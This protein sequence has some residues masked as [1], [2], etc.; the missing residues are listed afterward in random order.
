[1][2]SYATLGRSGLRVSPFTLGTMTF[3]EDLGWGGSP[4]ESTRILAAYLD[5]GGNS[6]HP[7]VYTNGHSEVIIGDYLA[8]RPGPRDRIV[9]GTKFFWNLRLGDP[10][11]G[12]PAARPSSSSW[13]TRCAACGPL[14]RHLLAAQLRPG[15]APPRP[16]A[17]LTTSSP[18]ARSATSG[19]LTCRRGRRP[20]RR[21]S[22][23]SAAGRRSSPCSWSTPCSS[24]PRR[25]SLSRWP[26]R[27]AWECALEPAEVRL[28]FR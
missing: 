6:V 2:T 24:G 11:G 27:W 22:P 21:P 19:S 14:R 25:E 3:G 28:P 12:G 18:R 17:S 23:G 15:H 5:R 4:E 26:R 20:R 8:G 9:L 7:N 16:C 13:R 1:M 10:N